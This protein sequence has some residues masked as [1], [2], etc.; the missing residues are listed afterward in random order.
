VANTDFL[1]AITL[2]QTREA[3][4]TYLVGNPD[5]DR[6]PRVGCRRADILK[7]PL[8]AYRR[9]ADP[10]TEGFKAAARF[11]HEQY[12]FDTRFLPYGTQAI[13]LSAIFTVLSSQEANTVGARQKLARWLWCGIFGELYGGTTETRFAR[14]LPEVVGW[15]RGAD[16][17]PRTVQE[18]QFAPGRLDTLRTR[19]SAAY[20]GIYALLMKDRAA[21]WRSGELINVTQ[22]FDLA[23][24]IHH[25]FPKAWCDKQGIAPAVYNTIANKTPLTAQTNRIIQ[26]RAPSLYLPALARSAGAP[27][28]AIEGHVTTHAA[29]PAYMLKDG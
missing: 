4:E 23:I 9:W 20:K 12:M 2:L 17:E 22:Y 18:A 6:V 24:D 13:P 15:I 19:G 25:I 26:G 14:D 16:T 27:Q 28:E 8:D 11:L 5:D 1:Q 10:L 7:L 29:D 3:R 21:D